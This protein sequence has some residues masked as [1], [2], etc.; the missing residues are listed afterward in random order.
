MTSDASAAIAAINGIV[1][2]QRGVTNME[3]G[4]SGMLHA[5]KMIHLS[6]GLYQGNIKQDMTHCMVNDGNEQFPPSSQSGLF[7]HVLQSATKWRTT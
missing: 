1:Y 7:G 6:S 3:G 5:C 2:D 4:I